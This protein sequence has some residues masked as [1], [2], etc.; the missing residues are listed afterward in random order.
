MSTRS[1]ASASATRPTRSRSPSLD[2]SCGPLDRRLELHVRLAHSNAGRFERESRQQFVRNRSGHRLEERELPPVGDRADG[3]DDLAIVDR[4]LD[5][6]RERVVGNLEP[7]VVDE[8]LR[9]RALFLLDP[10]PALDLQAVQLDRDHSAATACAARSA[11]TCART[12]WTRRI[13][14]PRS[15]AA[16]AAPTLAAV[17]PACAPGSPINF[18][19]ELLRE[20]PTRIGRPSAA[21]SSRRRKS[22]KLCSTVLPKP[23]PGSRQI[24]SSGIPC[25]TAK[26]SLSSRNRATSATTSSYRGSTC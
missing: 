3:G 16:T 1:S 14:A 15:Y 11:S 6:V 5:S 23:I 17:V 21:S 20:I 10:V 24:S 19:S 25:E 8:P 26:V 4:V 12:S 9:P 22:S 13:V 2:V 7:K 18:P